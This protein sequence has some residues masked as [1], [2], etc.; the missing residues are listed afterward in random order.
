MIAVA[1]PESAGVF[2]REL[3]EAGNPPSLVYSDGL[4]SAD[5]FEGLGWEQFEGGYGTAA[6]V[7]ETEAGSAFEQAWEA[8]YGALP[9]LPYLR[10]V[11]DAVY[12]FAL[13]AEQTDSVDATVLRDALRNVAS[14]PGTTVSP[15]TEG[16]QM[17]LEAISGGEDVN[18]EGAIGPLDFDEN[19]DVA[20]GAIVVWKIE[21][22]QIVD[23]ESRAVDLAAGG[24]TATPMATPAA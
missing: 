2:L 17:A 22:E 21:G 23:Q 14:E 11:Y 19:G 9:P 7:L 24:E 10:E 18:Y 12:L 15:G 16:W 20:T 5:L 13:A 6:G 8:S 4:K 3:I 1:Y